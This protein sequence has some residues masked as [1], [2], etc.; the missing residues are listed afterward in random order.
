MKKILDYTLILIILLIFLPIVVMALPFMIYK[1]IIF[2]WHV[3]RFYK[4]NNDRII[5]WYS[6]KKK[7]IELNKN[8]VLPM[9]VKDA[10]IIF[11]NQ[12]VIESS[13]NG[14]ILNH[15]RTKFTDKK[16]PLVI[17]INY[18]KMNAESLYSIFMDYKMRKNDLSE[19]KEKIE[20]L[21]NSLN[22]V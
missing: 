21:I 9:I 7:F 10:I 12:S 16:L 17:K 18:K 13:L 5:F 4:E 8:I 6:S 22:S 20:E 14:N 1:S 15:I 11:N 2:E 19:T 3:Y